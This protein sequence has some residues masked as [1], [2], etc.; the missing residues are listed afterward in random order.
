MKDY[1]I[2]KIT[3]KTM[4]Y[5]FRTKNKKFVVLSIKWYKFSQLFVYQGWNEKDFDT[6]LWNTFKSLK[7]FNKG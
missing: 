7:E 3:I 1:Q 5:R 4:F 6:F 2:G